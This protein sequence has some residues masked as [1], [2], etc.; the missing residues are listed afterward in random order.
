MGRTLTLDDL[1]ELCWINVDVIRVF[2]HVFL[3]FGRT[4]LY[5]R[6]IQM[7]AMTEDAAHHDTAEYAGF[8]GAIGSTDATHIQIELLPGD[9]WL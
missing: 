7:P 3:K 1:E 2:L 5:K 6:Y 4:G 8:P 9:N